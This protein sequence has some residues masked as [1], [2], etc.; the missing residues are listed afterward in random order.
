MSMH[1]ITRAEEEDM[2]QDS[3]TENH[4]PPQVTPPPK[5]PAAAP[6]RALFF[7]GLLVVALLL[8][9]AI[10][11]LTR[12]HSSRVLADTTAQNAVPTV[13]VVHPTDEK[14]DEELVL[15][16]TLQAY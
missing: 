3:S 8:A 16:G 12:M 4:A 1:Q 13:A 5:L 7:V 6:R 2:P 10:S 9:G 15:P 14:P 11:L